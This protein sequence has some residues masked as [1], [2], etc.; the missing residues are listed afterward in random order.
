MN[1]F[2]FGH[3]SSAQWEEAVQHCLFQMGTI[4]PDANLGFLYM[5]DLLVES[6]PD[7][8]NMFKQQTGIKHWVGTTSIG[9]CSTGIEYF[10]VPAIAVM[11]GHFPEE[12]FQVF[13]SITTHEGFEHFSRQHRPWCEEKSCML[14]V[15]HGDPT[16]DIISALIYQL[17]ERLDEAF[18][19]GG[20]TNSRSYHIQIADDVVGGNNL[21]LSGVLFSS[22]VAVSTHLTQSCY[23][24]GQR[25]QITEAERNMIFHID[26]RPALDVFYQEVAPYYSEEIEHIVHDVLVGLPIQ[27][28]DMNDYVVRNIIGADAEN[29]VLA[30]GDYVQA[31]TP[32][33]F[34]QRDKEMAYNDL[35]KMLV[36]FKTHNAEPKG[37]LYYS[38]LGRGAS[39]FGQNSEELRV[40]KEVLGDIPLVG[41]FANGEIYHQR[42]YSYTGILTLFF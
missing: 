1:K 33:T 34:V 18:L 27:G 4:S 42:V 21:G 14:G 39:L 40:I 37:A 28:S 8:L 6:S 20:L 19:V 26:N 36:H 11:V 35:K 3:A 25:H 10:D 7:I 23:P 2:Q 15:V 9:I 5:T 38:C 30:I 24:I 17:S 32:I 16:N 31:G 22:N 41:F 29:R 13:N 12:S